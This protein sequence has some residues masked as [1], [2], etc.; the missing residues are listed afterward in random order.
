[1]AADVKVRVSD[2]WLVFDG[3]TQRSGGQELTVPAD[4]AERWVEAG[5]VER[6]TV[7][8]TTTTKRQTRRP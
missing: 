8:A 4:L 6:V 1:M 2:G 3:K 5:W 7:K